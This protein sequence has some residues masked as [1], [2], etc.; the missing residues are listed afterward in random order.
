LPKKVTEV[1]IST[2]F[3][4]T[5][6]TAG[7]SL[8]LIWAGS[9]AAAAQTVPEKTDA[10]PAAKAA[11]PAVAKPVLKAEAPKTD[12]P[13]KAPAK[14]AAPAT[15]TA[16]TISKPAAA[17]KP[18]TIVTADATAKPAIKTTAKKTAAKP[19]A[20]TIDDM[21]AEGDVSLTLAAV[22]DWIITSK[23]N[24]KQPFAV[25]DKVNAQILIFDAAGKLK[26][27]APILVGSAMGDTSAEGVGDRELKDIPDEEKTTPA[28]RFLAAYGPA[29]NGERV[30]WIDYNTSISI[31]PVLT[32]VAAKW[33]KRAQRLSS[34]TAEDNR[35]THGCIN[36]EAGFYAST[37]RPNFKKGG[38]FYILP[39]SISLLDAFP[40][41]IPPS[42]AVASA[43]SEE[44]AK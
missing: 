5:L 23:D 36:V 44:A 25:I 41:Y 3:A 8:A 35:I 11:A 19:K 17:T 38:L 18:A 6:R 7:L 29:V 10:P 13:A 22:T 33:E 43:G 20:K 1:A 32:T 42:A 31:H 40:A 14:A 27:K 34:K 12:A 15:T 26:G 21:A 4:A 9:A 28:G 16:Q 2:R 30:L 24:R 37:V 39:D